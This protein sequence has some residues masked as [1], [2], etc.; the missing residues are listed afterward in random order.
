MFYLNEQ[1]YLYIL[2]CN[3]T[4]DTLHET[5][6]LDTQTALEIEQC[7]H[8]THIQQCVLNWMSTDDSRRDLKKASPWIIVLNVAI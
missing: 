2:D 5:C 8:R 3:Q 7:K 6:K 1:Q 4:L